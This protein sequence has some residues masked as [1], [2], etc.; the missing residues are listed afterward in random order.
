MIGATIGISRPS[1]CDML[2]DEKPGRSKILQNLPAVT[3][4]AKSP[5]K[6]H[7]DGRDLPTIALTIVRMA[8]VGKLEAES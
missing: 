5:G 6:W 3:Y 2:I 7:C 8:T 4:R 1:R